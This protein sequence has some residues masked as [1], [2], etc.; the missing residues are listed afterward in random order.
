MAWLV[1]G[2]IP[3]HAGKTSSAPARTN[4]GAAHPRSRGENL[5]VNTG[6]QWTGGLIPAHAGKTRR[7]PRSTV[8]GR[9]HP[10]SRG[11][12]GVLR[13]G[14]VKVTGSS[15]L[16]RGKRVSS[17]AVS[18]R[19]GLIPA[20]AGKT[21]P[22]LY[23]RRGTWAHP[24]SRGE[25][26]MLAVRCPRRPGSSPLTR[27]KPSP[28]LSPCQASGL[29]PAHAGKTLLR[30]PRFGHLGAHP[31][32]R[33]ENQPKWAGGGASSGSSPL[34]RGKLACAIACARAIGLIPAHAGKTDAE[35]PVML[36]VRA[37]PR[38]R[39]ENCCTGAGSALKA[40]SSPLTRGK[41][42]AGHVVISVDG[43][44]PA[45]AGKTSRAARSPISPTAHPRSRGENAKGAGSALMGAGSS[46]LTRGKLSRRA[47][48]LAL[49]RLIPAH[50]GKTRPH[51]A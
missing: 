31:R 8:S 10:R 3:A 2:L 17:A 40:G 15:P 21:L 22:R 6:D 16:T 45:H 48:G 28:R 1:E 30:R 51:R 14:R 12:N 18:G 29:I 7:P 42:L 9:A 50:A 11:E 38:S 47:G 33:G 19:R 23:Q 24:R 4:L 37:H 34:T 13:N 25:N 35:P 46:P 5:V 43:L 39:G 49:A 36:A 44:I 41:H 26:V 32:S 27:G 20:H